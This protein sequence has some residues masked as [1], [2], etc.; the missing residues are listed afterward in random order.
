MFRL[1]WLQRQGMTYCT[2]KGKTR[3]REQKMPMK[4]LTQA[5][6]GTLSVPEDHII[7]S[8][9]DTPKANKSHGE[10]SYEDC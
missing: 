2:L 9:I 8:R 5:V 4:N 7:I 10:I 3:A 6:K 1:V